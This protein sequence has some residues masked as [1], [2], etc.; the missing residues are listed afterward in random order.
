LQISLMD[1]SL[2]KCFGGW[3]F[4]MGLHRKESLKYSQA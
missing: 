2:V 3:D 1:A 4:L